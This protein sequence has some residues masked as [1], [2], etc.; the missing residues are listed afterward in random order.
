M[1]PFADG[2]YDLA[3]SAYG[4][5]PFVADPR[6]V[7]REVR[8]CC[9]PAAASSSPSRTRCAGRSR[10]SRAPRLTVSSSYFDRTPYVEQD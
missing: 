1:L 4:T 8:R 9:G 10:T 5:L 3:C 2:S 6:L 7:L